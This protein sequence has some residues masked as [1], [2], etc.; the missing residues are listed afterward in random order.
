[1]ERGGRSV[2]CR[3]A[4]FVIEGAPVRLTASPSCW[5]EQGG[6]ELEERPVVDV[7]VGRTV[8][9]ARQQAAKGEVRFE[10]SIVS[11]AVGRGGSRAQRGNKFIDSLRR[12]GWQTKKN[13]HRESSR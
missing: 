10:F 5:P 8:V 2:F 4:E 12:P 13:I 3:G 11:D 1:V 6:R 7:I 9:E